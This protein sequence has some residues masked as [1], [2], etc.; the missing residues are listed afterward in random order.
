VVEAV[1]DGSLLQMRLSNSQRLAITSELLAV[2]EM[3]ART[4]KDIPELMGP[5]ELGVRRASPVCLASRQ[6]PGM[7]AM[8]ETVATAHSEV[9]GAGMEGRVEWR[10]EGAAGTAATPGVAALR[11]HKS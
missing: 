7:V 3:M 5:M 1:A 2:M 6:S 10:L 9:D 8:A 4:H 11:A